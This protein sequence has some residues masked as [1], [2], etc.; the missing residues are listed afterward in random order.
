MPAL[1]VSIIVP[2][3]NEAA[4][5]E[6]FLRHLAER[7]PGWE[8]V[9]ADGG[10]EDGTAPLAAPLARV[11]IAPRGRARQMNAGAAVA[12]GEAFWFLHA[13]S[14]LPPEAPAALTAALEVPE[15]AGGCFRLRLPRRGLAYRIAD[16]LGNLGVD[17]FGFALG[18]HGIFARRSAFEAAGRFSDLPLME[19]AEFYRALRKQGRAPQLRPRIETSPRRWEARGPGRTTGVYL[20]LLAGY[21]LGVSPPRLAGWH[22]RLL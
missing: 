17:V 5:I 15:V 20:L 6:G 12:G 8:I 4:G 1:A 13:N 11:I 16:D 18:D 7:C 21:C 14:R 3:L 19:D 22:R 2:T 10:S 9:V